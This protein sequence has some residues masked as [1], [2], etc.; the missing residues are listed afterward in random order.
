M[1]KYGTRR[2]SHKSP[3]S[4][5]QQEAQNMGMIGVF[6]GSRENAVLYIASAILILIL[7]LLGTLMLVDQNVRPDVLNIL[8][9][10]GVATIGYIGGLI[11]K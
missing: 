5:L 9:A 4:E 7:C 6:L 10:I 1:S 2:D 8:G 11:S 3:N